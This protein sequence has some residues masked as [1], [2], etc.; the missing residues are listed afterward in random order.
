MRWRYRDEI[1]ARL[2]DLAVFP[3]PGTDPVIVRDY[4]KALYTMEIRTLRV[5]QQRRIRAGERMEPKAY[6]RQVIELRE[7]YDI[8]SIPVEWWTQRG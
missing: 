3:T 8:L 6:A 4:L 7:R 2:H 1:L 5:D